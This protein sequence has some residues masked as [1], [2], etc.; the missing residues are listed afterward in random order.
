MATQFQ[1]EL[2]RMRGLRSQTEFAADLGVSRAT[3]AAWDGGRAAPS[4]SLARK[5]V[6]QGMDPAVVLEAVTTPRSRATSA[7]GQGHAA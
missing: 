5:L 6:A 7:A 2:R 4:L 1:D 3:I